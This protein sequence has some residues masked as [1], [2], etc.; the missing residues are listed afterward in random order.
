MDPTRSR[1]LARRLSAD[2]IRRLAECLDH[3]MTK[4]DRALTDLIPTLVR[5]HHQISD[6]MAESILAAIR[7]MREEELQWLCE[8]VHE[9]V[10]R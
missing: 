8:N 6:A 3:A 5:G 2:A 7:G 1:K 9:L 4:P 10:R